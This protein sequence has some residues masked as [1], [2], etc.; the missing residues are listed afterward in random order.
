MK[1]LRDSEAPTQSPSA[2]PYS[3][4]LTVPLVHLLVSACIVLGVALLVFVAW[5]P[6]P[7]GE[8]AGGSKLFW[9]VIAVDVVCGP[10]LTWLLYSPKKSRFALTIDISLIVFI[11]I[12]ALAYGMYSLSISRPIAL[13]YEVDRFRLLSVADI[14]EA[15]AAKAPSWVSHWGSSNVRVLGIRPATN[16]DEKLDSVNGALQGV[17]PS[18][19]P[20]WWQDYALSIPSVLKRARP[21]EELRQKHP[22]K[23]EVLNKAV[24]QAIAEARQGETTNSAQLLWLPLVGRRSLEWVVLLDPVTARPRGYVALDGF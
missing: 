23:L 17:E 16:L 7:L 18:Q 21:L 5:F 15:E 3:G 10:F 4:M 12:A 1:H 9:L 13:V 2:M 6:E 22:T 19:R 20:D 11:Q 8:L 24:E 14:P